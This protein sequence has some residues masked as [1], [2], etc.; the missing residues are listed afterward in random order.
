MIVVIMTV[1]VAF[2]LTVSEAKYVIMCF[3]NEID[4]DAA[5]IF[6]V[7][8]AGQVKSRFFMPREERQLRRRP[9]HRGRRAHMQHLAH[10]PEVLPSNNTTER[11]RPL[12]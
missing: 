1:C 4:N 6:S 8:A 10:L 9:A 2:G 3:T 11:A 7:D 12:C 5:S